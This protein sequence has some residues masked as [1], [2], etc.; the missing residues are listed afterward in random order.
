MPKIS[1]YDPDTSLATTDYLLG[2]KASGPSTQKFRLSDLIAFFWTLG[3]IPTGGTSPVTRDSEMGFDFIASNTGVITADSVG[4]NKNASITSIT[5][6]IGGMRVVAPASTARTY[7]A[8]KDTYID[9]LN[10]ND[11]TGTLVFTEVTNNAAS[12]A[13]SA[14]SFR[15]GI[16]VTGATTIAAVGS[17]NQGQETK[18]LP[19]GSSIPY[20]VTDSLG[21]LICPRDPQRKVLGYRANIAGA[22]TASATDVQL[23]GVT[24]PVI[25]PLGR[26]VEIELVGLGYNNNVN[27]GVLATIWEGTVGAGTQ[28]NTG[29]YEKNSVSPST[30]NLHTSAVRTPS[31]ASVTYN[32]GWHAAT[33]GTG[34]INASASTPNFI[35]VKLG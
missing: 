6:Y 9:C 22:A 14:N 29:G 31:T 21:N 28:L 35:K 17:I 7:T 33:A 20:Q 11:G 34:N 18:V 32:F 5:G 19:I 27:D 25:V 15:V 1:T 8:S 2:N 26:K 23:L 30:S 12:P 3:N 13:L 10:N 4:V 24:V 16:V